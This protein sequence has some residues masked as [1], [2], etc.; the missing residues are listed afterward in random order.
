LSQFAEIAEYGPNRKINDE[1]SLL[2][3]VYIVALESSRQYFLGHRN[4][5]LRSFGET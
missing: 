1:E 2:G 5:I 3:Y 4:C